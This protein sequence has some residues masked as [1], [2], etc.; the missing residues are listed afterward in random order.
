M[1]P[2]LFY[3]Y[4][5]YDPSR[6]NEPI[7]VGQGKMDRVWEH[8]KSTFNHPFVNRLKHMK[9]NNISPNIGIYAGM[10]EELA[11]LLE[12][13]LI[14]KFG[15]KDLKQGPLLNLTNGGG[16]CVRQNIFSFITVACEYIKSYKRQNHE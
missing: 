12:I 3:T 6:N 1:N 10:D 5:Y 2:E 9:N 14:A 4:I 13:E 16:R 7:Y 11:L 8:L 15:R